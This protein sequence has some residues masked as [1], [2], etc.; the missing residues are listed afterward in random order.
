MK[1]VAII[2]IVGIPAQYG[3]FERFTE[4][5]VLRLRDRFE[6]TV[7]CQKSAFAVRP[8]KIGD[9]SLRYL[10]L[11]ANGI[12]S[13]FYDMTAI[14][15]ALFYADTLLILGVSG[16]GLLPLLRFFGCRKTIV[17]NIDG[18][19]WRRAKWNALARSYLRFSERCAVRCADEVIG[20]NRV[21][22]DYVRKI[23][24]RDCR[25]IEYGADNIPFES[26]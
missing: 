3:G 9:V 6:F 25:L 15:H 10:P 23:Y 11:R 5:L 4:Q 21:I 22:V 1:K 8:E 17:V 14:V 18:I 16:C 20:D 26:E 13:I 2:G 12:S 24:R 7:Y 19:E